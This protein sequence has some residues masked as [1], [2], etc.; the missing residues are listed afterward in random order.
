MLFVHII[1][2]GEGE[3]ELAGLSEDKELW[4]ILPPEFK[5]LND[6]KVLIAKPTIKNVVLAIKHI[7]GYRKV[8]VKID[9]NLREEYFDEDENLCYKGSPLEEVNSTIVSC[10]NENISR[11]EE[12]NFLREK[13]IELES[14][15]SKTEVKLH[16]VEKKFVLDKF[17][18]TQNPIEW[19]DR[20]HS[21]C[22]RL[23][24]GNEAKK[25][26]IL[27]FFVDGPSKDW[28]ETNLKKIIIWNICNLHILKVIINKYI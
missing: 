15:L 21:E 28:Y 18:K 12:E 27:R 8:G 23:N 24:V 2:R 14:K 22:E 9:Q 3:Y 1:K 11:T 6:H 19:L 25:I 17:D 10:V 20:Y 7:N 26:E 16:E 4:Y 13:I 5:N